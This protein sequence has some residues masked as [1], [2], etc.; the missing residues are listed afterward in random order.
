[1]SPSVTIAG[2]RLANKTPSQ[3]LTFETGFSRL[4]CSI[5]RFH[6][7][8]DV[9]VSW[10]MLAIDLAVE[11]RRDNFNLHHLASGLSRGTVLL[12]PA[13]LRSIRT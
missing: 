1:M 10:H 11:R 12:F 2:L 5:S 3:T 9:S 8:Q 6:L 4:N 13:S 7:R